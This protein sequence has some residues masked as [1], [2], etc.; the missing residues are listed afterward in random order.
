MRKWL[1][2]AVFLVFL[3]QI[4]V[5]S[6]VSFYVP[7]RD[8][9]DRAPIVVEAEVSAV[10]YGYD[11][12]TSA[13]AT[14]VTLR[15]VDSHRGA[16][17]LTEI[18][19]RERGGR[20]GPWVHQTDAVPLYRPGER[21]LVFVERA[22]DGSPRTAH[23]FFG[24]FSLYE[25][26]RPGHRR[27]I[28]DLGGQGTIH[29]R[30]GSDDL[31][32][33]DL[34]VV[35]SA[36]ARGRRPSDASG[37][38]VQRSETTLAPPEIHRLLWDGGRSPLPRAS[39][40]DIE[41][42]RLGPE[43]RETL[44]PDFSPLSKSAPVRWTGIDSGQS[45]VVHMEPDRNPLGDDLLAAM[46]IRRAAA[47]WTAV[48]ESRLSVTTG[49]EQDDFT[50]TNSQ[51]PSRTYPPRNVVLFGDPY[52][53]I[54]DPSGC[55]GTL[56]IGGYWRSGTLSGTVNNVS[57]YPA[58]RLYVIFNDQFECFLGNPDN[59]SE[60]ATHELGHGL[61]F[62]HSSVSDAVMRPQAY[63]AG[64]GPRLGDD[65]RD[66]A[67]CH[68]PHQFSLV[69]PNGGE[70]WTV[71]EIREVRWLLSAESGSAPE[72]VDIERAVDGGVTWTPVASAVHNNGSFDWQVSPP[73]GTKNR[74][75]VT[76]PNRVFPTPSPYPSHCSSDASDGDFQVVEDIGT[77]GAVPET[78]AGAL[79]ADP[80]ADRSIVLSWGRSCS[81]RE[82][83]YA[84]YEGSLDSLRSGQW[85]HGAVTCAAGIDRSHS[86]P[87]ASGAR[88]F[89][90]APLAD[91]KQGS[92]G[93]SSSGPRP[94]PS[95][96]CGPIEPPSC[97]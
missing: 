29:G 48:P 75:R 93:R 20:F 10:G 49:N 37:R 96:P 34:R 45:V 82:D 36:I 11:P 32:S 68:Y 2:V 95:A 76:R 5:R 81:A 47:A 85:D 18:V 8:L 39:G 1:T 97:P 13:L 59:L 92:S 41:T 6:A 60:V 56:A 69:T 9:V 40:A 22:R 43:H 50:T 77:A 73:A 72:T 78:G 14:Y 54:T 17:A 15:V 42:E 55:S 38:S 30:P 63:G 91:G 86:F 51:S 21:V 89:L 74:L 19:L 7:V 88:Y 80:G 23:G 28:R 26:A 16:P 64:R 79:R 24:K 27:A 67:H 46:Q 71:G 94:D 66:G 3:H 61:G 62:G 70:A 12:D 33:F 58:L 53:E 35:L 52:D 4:P 44:D 65:D 25:G 57:F 87:P 31:E 83:D 90:V 84:V